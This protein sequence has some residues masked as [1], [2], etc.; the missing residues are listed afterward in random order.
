MTLLR[1]LLVLNIFQQRSIC[2]HQLCN[3]WQFTTYV[4]IK[5]VY[6]NSKGNDKGL[7][8]KLI[9]ISNSIKFF[10]VFSGI[11]MNGFF[12]LLYRVLDFVTLH[13]MSRQ[14]FWIELYHK[15]PVLLELQSQLW[16]I[17]IAVIDF[18]GSHRQIIGDHVT[19]GS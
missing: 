3:K 13:D 2:H 6:L 11:Y 9:L 5:N 8:L 17:I 16:Y 7:A 4:S 14:I 12:L 15:T 1:L 18:L 10:F 19:N